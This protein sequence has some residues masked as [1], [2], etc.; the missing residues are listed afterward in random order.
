MNMFIL[1]MNMFILL[2]TNT[3]DFDFFLKGDTSVDEVS[4]PKPHAW[5][6]D[7]GWKDLLYLVTMEGK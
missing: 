2:H 5:M 1:K 3:K 7:S 6:P 4:T